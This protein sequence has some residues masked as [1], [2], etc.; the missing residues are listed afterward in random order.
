MLTIK[1]VNPKVISKAVTVAEAMIANNMEEDFLDKET[2]GNLKVFLKEPKV[3][4]CG[5]V[6][7]NSESKLFNKEIF[8]GSQEL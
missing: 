3:I 1:K 6:V 5:F 7:N 2:F 8:I 4:F